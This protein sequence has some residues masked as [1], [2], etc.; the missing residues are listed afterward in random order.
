MKKKRQEK[1]KKRRLIST[2]P[3]SPLPRPSPELSYRPPSITTVR[4]HLDTDVSTR[5][6]TVST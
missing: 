3:P 2:E 4:P 5:E 1:K 6:F